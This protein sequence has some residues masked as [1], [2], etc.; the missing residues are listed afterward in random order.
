MTILLFFLFFRFGELCENDVN[1][2]ASSTVLEQ[3]PLLAG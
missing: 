1:I 2:S 3:L